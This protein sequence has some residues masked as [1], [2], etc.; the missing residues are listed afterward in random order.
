MKSGWEISVPHQICIEV[1][2]VLNFILTVG[3]DVYMDKYGYEGLRKNTNG[4][5]TS[6]YYLDNEM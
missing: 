2:C 6:S 3:L 4:K 1:Q 5:T